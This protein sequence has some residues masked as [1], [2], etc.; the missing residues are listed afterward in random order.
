M[1]SLFKQLNVPVVLLSSLLLI[2]IIVPAYILS[3]IFL[4]EKT[5][6]PFME[7]MS[8]FERGE[9]YFSSDH[10]DLSQARYYYESSIKNDPQSNPLQWYQLARINFLE[11]EFDTAIHNLDKQREYFGDTVPN[12]HYMYGLVYGFRA[13][14]YKRPQD[15]ELAEKHFLQFLEYM[16]DSPWGRID[17]S[18]IYFSQ[19]EFDNMLLAL[20]PVYDQEQDN[21]WFLNMYGLAAMNTGEP[22][23]AVKYMTR[24]VALSSEVQ[25]ADWADVYPG[26]SPTDWEV[27]LVEF[28]QA[29][30]L[31]LALAEKKVEVG[32][33]SVQTQD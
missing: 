26:N 32:G 11:A 3:G 1:Q 14:M 19:R 16:P 31:N 20:D 17:L 5:V 25:V 13:D 21:P 24:A 15:F 7:N 27:G 2:S 10:Y 22:E 8:D 33:D 30:K 18:W 6:E 29:L 12:V 23:M 4:E 28:G 9:Y